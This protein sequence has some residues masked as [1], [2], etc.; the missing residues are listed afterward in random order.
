MVVWI[1]IVLM[2]SVRAVLGSMV[3]VLDVVSP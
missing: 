2:L 3:L 1:S